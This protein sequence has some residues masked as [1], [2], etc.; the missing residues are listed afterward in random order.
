MENIIEISKFLTLDGAE[1]LS[2]ILLD[3]VEES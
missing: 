1:G 3:R 2:E